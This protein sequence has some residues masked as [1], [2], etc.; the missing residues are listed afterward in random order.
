MLNSKGQKTMGIRDISKMTRTKIIYSTIAISSILFILTANYLIIPWIKCFLNGFNDSSGATIGIK[1]SKEMGVLL[2]EY[3]VVPNFFVLPTGEK[4]VIEK[5]Y[6]ERLWHYDT[7]CKTTYKISN[8]KEKCYLYIQFSK[9]K[10]RELLDSK[11]Y[12]LIWFRVDGE[13]P[14][15]GFN[16][17]M[18][19]GGD[20]QRQEIQYLDN[21]E[22]KLHLLV[23]KKNIEKGTDYGKDYQIF[24]ELVLTPVK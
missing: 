19:M 9:G 22:H 21:V 3:C 12:A 5:V 18:L 2:T 6:S 20:T 4:F 7:Q 14:K 15:D 10:L 17:T 23:Y 16:Y 11:N 1:E 13:I 8:Q 24:G